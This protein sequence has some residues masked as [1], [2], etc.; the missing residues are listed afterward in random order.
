MLEPMAPVRHHRLVPGEI[1]KTPRKS[2][3][4]GGMEPQ[5]PVE[6]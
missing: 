3:S 5:E 4:S 2:A 1:A 6:R